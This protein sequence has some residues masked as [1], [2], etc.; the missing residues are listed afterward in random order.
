MSKT[1]K[2]LV[3]ILRGTSDANISFLK[4]RNLLQL[5]GFEERIRGDHYIYTR[6]D[7]D[8]IINIQPAGAQSKPYQIKQ[9]REIILKYKLNIE[10]K[11]A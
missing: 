11:N 8:E 10:V 7:I 5:F 6:D 1:E 9:I 3:K 4:L 2:L